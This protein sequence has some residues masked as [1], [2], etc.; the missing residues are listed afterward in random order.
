MST[1]SEIT[2]RKALVCKA[3]VSG[4][5]LVSESVRIGMPP[6]FLR[7]WARK[8]FQDVYIAPTHKSRTGLTELR[9]K[10]A[11][12]WLR[13]HATRTHSKTCTRYSTTRRA[14]CG[15]PVRKGRFCYEC[16]ASVGGPVRIGAGTGSRLVSI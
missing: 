7:A 11:S 9:I 2:H 4:T 5:S 8:N 13:H 15:E 16:A 14:Y 10:L 12:D 6:D 3:L 1:Q